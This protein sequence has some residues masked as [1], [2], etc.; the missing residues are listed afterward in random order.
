MKEGKKEAYL[1][2]AMVGS[3][4]PF[5]DAKVKEM[6]SPSLFPL[7]SNLPGMWLKVILGV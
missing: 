3:L 1:Q 2:R 6:K 4:V 5:K 7:H